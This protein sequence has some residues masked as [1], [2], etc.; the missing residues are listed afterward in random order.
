M[1][2]GLKIAILALILV[3][4][5]ILAILTFSP[6][7]LE[8]DEN[9]ISKIYNSSYF[10]AKM[11]NIDFTQYGDSPEYD[12]IYIIK[13]D[14]DYKDIL[15]KQNK[16]KNR[17]LDRNPKNYENTTM[18]VYVKDNEIITYAN[19]PENLIIFET[20][21]SKYNKSYG[22]FNISANGD[23]FTIKDR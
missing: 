22:E 9:V 7:K 15:F 14:E 13:K 11:G 17:K 4:C 18:F 12:D 2:K 21:N 16:V 8:P 5:I 10:C 3:V 6:N 19:I 23:K 1:K 20:S